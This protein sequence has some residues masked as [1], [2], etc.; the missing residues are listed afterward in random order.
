MSGNICVSREIYNYIKISITTKIFNQLFLYPLIFGTL[1]CG[2]FYVP[3]DKLIQKYV[4]IVHVII[5]F[6]T[7]SL[8]SRHFD[9]DLAKTWSR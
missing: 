7:V 9:M 6:C 1:V 3:R 5:L 8:V 4:Y 2:N